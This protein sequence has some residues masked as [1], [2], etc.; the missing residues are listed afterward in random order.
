VVNPA[1]DKVAEPQAAT[2]KDE[3]KPVIRLKGSEGGRKKSR[4]KRRQTT[5][6]IKEGLGAIFHFPNEFWTR[7]RSAFAALEG[8][9]PYS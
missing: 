7:V 6:D 4:L 8:D 3:G 2:H 5:L 1:G 9:G